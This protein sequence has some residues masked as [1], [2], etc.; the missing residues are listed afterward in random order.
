MD[1]STRICHLLVTILFSPETE[2]RK[3]EEQR[4]TQTSRHQ[5]RK[6][7]MS[8]NLTP[9]QTPMTELNS[10]FETI[11]EPKGEWNGWNE[12]A[13]S[14][15]F[16][17]ETVRGLQL[18]N[19]QTPIHRMFGRDK[20]PEEDFDYEVMETALR[21]T[22][23][24]LIACLPVFY[25]ILEGSTFQTGEVDDQG[26]PMWYFVD[27]SE[28][29]TEEQTN[30]VWTW[31]DKWSDK[32]NFV[33][34]RASRGEE[35]VPGDASCTPQYETD[36]WPECPGCGSEI[37]I[38]LGLY[39]MLLQASYS[40]DDIILNQWAAFYFAIAIIHELGHAAVN[41]TQP[42]DWSI[43][44]C[45]L[46]E[47]GHTVEMGF[48]V[49]S[50]L[51]GGVIPWVRLPYRPHIVDENT[52]R[53]S[54]LDK[55]L[56]ARTY[57]CPSTTAIYKAEFGFDIKTWGGHKGVI[58]SWNV[59]FAHIAK[60]LRNE[61][62]TGEYQGLGRKALWFDKITGYRLDEVT[63]EPVRGNEHI[64]EGYWA[65]ENGL[66]RKIGTEGVIQPTET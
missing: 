54:L 28:T 62:W 31:I 57:P 27:P 38:S 60:M 48:E 52:G 6:A 42:T 19:L 9:T 59:S 37:R 46:G 66:L 2:R 18:S 26:E 56:D 47:K 33:L 39:N 64:P 13:R 15:Y 50:W 4:E 24:F 10:V 41:A 8:D 7:I 12:F 16:R 63:W 55:I 45:C 3:K 32:V 22:P 36:L 49:Q 17:R 51:F 40:P 65:D 61:F 20:F 21:L 35:A 58:L 11:I 23:Q 14:G 5:R 34:P 1:I 43:D 25:S 53:E 29:L 30:E 44:L